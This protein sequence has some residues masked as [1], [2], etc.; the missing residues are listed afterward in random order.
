MLNPREPGYP[1]S[2]GVKYVLNPREPGYPSSG[3]KLTQRP[4]RRRR[5]GLCRRPRRRSGRPRPVARR[6]LGGHCPAGLSAR[7]Y[8]PPPHCP[9]LTSKVAALGKGKERKH[10]ALR[11]QKP[12][13]LIRDGKVG[14]G[15]QEFYI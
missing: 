13:R 4:D 1:S 9:R 8:W 14:G 10:L 5:A 6:S 11:P 7:S 15:G 12:L 3:G 2:G